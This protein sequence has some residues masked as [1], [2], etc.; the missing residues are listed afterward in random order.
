M[1]LLSKNDNDDKS[2]FLL[3]LPLPPLYLLQMTTIALP[4]RISVLALLLLCLVVCWYSCSPSSW[5]WRMTT[6][7]LIRETERKQEWFLFWYIIPFLIL[8][9]PIRPHTYP[10]FNK[11]QRIGRWQRTQL[12]QH[13]Q[14]RSFPPS[15]SS[16]DA[17]LT[18][19]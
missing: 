1:I 16:F 15:P 19:I 11:N 3:P 13:H 5:L 9:Q 6:S 4:K 14:E 10:P 18:L 12:P 8:G 2:T 7:T 17:N